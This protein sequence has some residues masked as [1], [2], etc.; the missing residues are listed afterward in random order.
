MGWETDLLARIEAPDTVELVSALD[1]W[2]ASE[3]MPGWMHNPLAVATPG[4]GGVA[5]NA[6]GVMAYPTKQAG[7]DAT[8]ATLEEPR[9]D[10]L[11]SVLRSGADLRQV[12]YAVNG[13]AWRKGA[14]GGFYPMVLHTAMEADPGPGPHTPIHDPPAGVQDPV[15]W[16]FNELQD[17]QYSE[18]PATVTGLKWIEAYVNSVN[19]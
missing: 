3:G 7:V 15:Q 14:Q 12:W 5:M 17:W 13:S 18:G 11:L 8:A 9:F 4:Y 19:T 10:H 6:E 16:S 2:A 1:Y